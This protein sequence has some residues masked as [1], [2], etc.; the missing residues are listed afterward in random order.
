MAG[1]AEGS[2]V[3]RE[4]RQADHWR[5]QGRMG[6]ARVCARRAAGW[7]IVPLYRQATGENPPASALRLLDWYRGF[8]A[9]PLHLR[10]AAERLTAHVDRDHNLPFAEDPIDDARRIVEGLRSTTA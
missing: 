7:A 9:A 8:A 2:R 4:L 5:S 10:R 3:D 6:R 1:S